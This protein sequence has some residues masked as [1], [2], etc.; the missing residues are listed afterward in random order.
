[1]TPS[2]RARQTYFG[3]RLTRI[4]PTTGPDRDAIDFDLNNSGIRLGLAMH[5]CAPGQK[6]GPTPWHH[7]RHKLYFFRLGMTDRGFHFN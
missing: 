4:R 2:S 3:R 5:V 7:R 1:M 6:Q